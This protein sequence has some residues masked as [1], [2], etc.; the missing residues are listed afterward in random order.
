MY[1]LGLTLYE[2][3]AP[4]PAF[5]ERDRNKLIRQVCHDEARATLDD[6]P[7]IPRDL[8]TIVH[9]AIE[10]EPTRRYPTAGELAADLQRFLDDQPIR[11]RRASTAERVAVVASAQGVGGGPDRRG[12][13][14][15]GRDRDCGA[16][17][18]VFPAPGR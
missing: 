6:R 4:R 12:R 10:K 7:G 1:S 2:L 16:R 15:G 13:V 17:G 11:A 9:K 14:A 18:L 5:G 3:L 8:E